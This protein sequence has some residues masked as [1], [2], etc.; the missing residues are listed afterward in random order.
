MEKAHLRFLKSKNGDLIMT[1]SPFI[2]NES[3]YIDEWDEE[4]QSIK[5]NVPESEVEA[6][7]EDFKQEVE[8][9]LAKYPPL[10]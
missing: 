3:I 5:S 1:S 8:E 7:E 10:Q 6:E 2:L 4:F 9:V